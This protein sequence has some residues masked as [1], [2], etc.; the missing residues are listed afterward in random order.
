MAVKCP[1]CGDR[2]E[3]SG[4]KAADLVTCL[5]CQATVDVLLADPVQDD[6]GSP[7]AVSPASF[8]GPVR[9][10]P[11]VEADVGV[12][13][14]SLRS[15]DMKH[16]KEAV[17]GSTS[18]RP[19]TVERTSSA[20]QPVAAGP[21]ADDWLSAPDLR[22]QHVT[23]PPV[24]PRLIPTPSPVHQEP[25][26]SH[27]PEQ[28]SVE[29]APGKPFSAEQDWAASDMNQTL[30]RLSGFLLDPAELANDAGLAVSPGADVSDRLPPG[31]VRLDDLNLSFD[32][33]QPLKFQETS[34]ASRAAGDPGTTLDIDA[35]M[36]QE[37]SVDSI[38]RWV[39]PNPEAQRGVPNSESPWHMS[40]SSKSADIGGA[41]QPLPSDGRKVIED[42]PWAVSELKPATAPAGM[43]FGGHW[44]TQPPV[45]SGQG[46]QSSLE[47]DFAAPGAP[48]DSFG[49]S[50][51]DGATSASLQIEI[52]SK[53]ST[54]SRSAEIAPAGAAPLPV[55]R[56]ANGDRKKRRKSASTADGRS[57]AKPLLVA[58]LLVILV[59]VILGQTEY[60]YFGIGL[61][62]N[63]SS[64][65]AVRRA[66]TPGG[67]PGSGSGGVPAAMP[68]RRDAWQKEIVRIQRLLV[69]SPKDETLRAELLVVLSRLRE[70]F[71]SVLAADPALSAK[72]QEL[73]A[74][75]SMKGDAADLVRAADL[76]TAGNWA[77]ARSLVDRLQAVASSDPY[78]PYLAGKIAIG[79]DRFDDAL[80]AFDK[81]L[82]KDS[83][84]VAATYFSG[85]AQL[86]KQELVK[87]RSSFEAVLA[88][89]ADH[90]S[91]RLGL[92]EVLLASSDLE[93]AARL[94]NEVIAKGQPGVDSDE[95]FGA[96]VLLARVEDQRGAKDARLKEL[97]AALGI[98]P[99]DSSIAVEVSRL[100]R[101]EAKTGEALGVL[102]ASREARRDSEQFLSA[103]ASAAFADGK[104]DLAEVAVL[105][106]LQ[107]YPKSSVFHVLRG[108]RE[109]DQRRL[110]SA[111][112]SFDAALQVDPSAVDA[113]VLMAQGLTAE[114][115]LG[116]AVERLKEG[117]T[118]T[119]QSVSLL[120]ALAAIQKDQ[121]DMVGA[122]TT[123]RLAVSKDQDNSKAAQDLGL[124]VLSQGRMEEAAKILMDI[125]I[126]RQLDRDGVLGLARALMGLRQAAKAREVLQRVHD[127]LIDDWDVTAE[128]GR[129]MFESGQDADAES[130][131]RKVLQQRPT[132][133]VSFYYLGRLLTAR[134]DRKGA[135]DAFENSI[136]AN[137][138]NTLP[139]IELARIHME[140]RDN[141]SI[142]L[143]KAQ[144]DVVI[145]AYSRNEV[146]EEDRD[147]DAYLMHGRILFDEQK[148]TLAMKDFESALARAPTR[149]DIM[150]GF[151]RTLFEAARYDDARPYLRQV[152]GRDLQHPE[153]NYLMGRI[154]V[155]E[156]KSREARVHLERVV[157]RDARSFPEAYRLLGMIYRD[158]G[159]NA[160]ARTSFQSF[161][162]YADPKSGEA[163]EARQLLG[164]MRH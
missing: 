129:A 82:A 44:G 126:R 84:M 125:D 4:I 149:V 1:F 35:V 144:L 51:F 24:V 150:V 118:K 145:G 136:R 120:L 78:V 110:R 114:G 21:A 79:Q 117:L 141:E 80:R 16:A 65:Q 37:S 154:L 164:R 59:G 19:P 163:E 109:L 40:P 100:L 90:L 146:A 22:S 132:H 9:D 68:D 101:A 75:V 31:S 97:R 115:R 32:D 121:H 57:I 99:S 89:E 39:E 20:A 46:S 62:G 76:M 161:L 10:V 98:R 153:A 14:Y 74:Q 158:E 138:R 58:G 143:A 12:G 23:V 77:E 104:P 159:L 156:G 67:G 96:R 52:P 70:R 18:V 119:G 139:R 93:G 91:A 15:N 34:G 11:P 26:V 86:K 135:I 5:T 160:L 17:F 81:A 133:H 113:W 55:G 140:L 108:R 3:T 63:G 151:A 103:Y 60:G 85:Y 94:S 47:Y 2:I 88:R 152:L 128:L 71:P 162:R 105:E 28:V 33:L 95:L 155:R 69:D 43:D 7:D 106:G 49:A 53:G 127:S 66:V 107:K 137:S 83:S 56:A 29:K 116:E 41:K 48:P 157:Q 61:L 147:P 130:I 6:I 54:S 45:D 73:L 124:I 111:V 134:G 38:P 50:L 131:L 102:T 25:S 87:A 123:L 92:A 142:R 36:R 42:D 112:S 64:S 30:D 8:T 122:E 27:R 72:L 148:Y 13:S